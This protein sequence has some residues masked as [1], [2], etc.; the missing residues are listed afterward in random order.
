MPWQDAVS[1]KITLLCF[2]LTTMIQLW[3]QWPTH[4]LCTELNIAQ[5]PILLQLF[6]S[7]LAAQSTNCTKK[8]ECLMIQQLSAL[9]SSRKRIHSL[10]WQ[11]KHL[12]FKFEKYFG[13]LT[14]QLW[15]KRMMLNLSILKQTWHWGNLSCDLLQV[16]NTPCMI[17]M[18]QKLL[19]WQLRSCKMTFHCVSYHQKL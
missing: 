13:K 5:P 4:Y 12:S 6:Y 14:F 3:F 1:Q 2:T 10:R 8:L 15:W 7:S 11:K 19:T 17:D 9:N 16:A 18:H